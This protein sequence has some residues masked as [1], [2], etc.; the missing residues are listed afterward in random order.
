MFKKGILGVDDIIGTATSTL[1]DG[2]KSEGLIT[3]KMNLKMGN[4]DIGEVDVV[5]MNS[6]CVPIIGMEVF[7]RFNSW[8]IDNVN[9]KLIL[10][11]KK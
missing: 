2:S 8:T 9:Q 10:G 6:G 5:M 11:E 1:A 7:N 4:V 3:W